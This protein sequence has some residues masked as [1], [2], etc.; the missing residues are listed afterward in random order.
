[1]S[2][3]DQW[4]AVA[5]KLQEDTGTGLVACDARDGRSCCIT[6]DRQPQGL[7]LGVGWSLQVTAGGQI[8]R[9]FRALLRLS[10]ASL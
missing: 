4:H 3:A 2:H 5:W 10:P 6:G 1:M 8:P 7:K 9:R